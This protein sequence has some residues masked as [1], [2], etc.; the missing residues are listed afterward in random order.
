M[1]CPCSGKVWSYVKEAAWQPL[2]WGPKAPEVPGVCG[3]WWRGLYNSVL[4]QGGWSLWRQRGGRRRGPE[5][6]LQQ[7]RLQLHPQRPGRHRGAARP[8]WSAAD[9]WGGQRV[10][11]PGAAR[12]R[13]RSQHREHLQLIVLFFFLLILVESEFPAANYIGRARRQ[14]DTAPAYTL[15]HAPAGTHTCTAGPSA[16]W[17]LN[18]RPWWVQTCSITNHFS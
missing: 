12:R 13:W 15:S 5:P 9:P 8:L 3:L 18:N 7:R 16:W 2:R 6:L 10:L 11:Q 17:L 1:F 14:R 4:T